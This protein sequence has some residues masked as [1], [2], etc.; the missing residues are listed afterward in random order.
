MFG[1]R[2]AIGVGW[3]ALALAL[4][5]GC[6]GA[7][8]H[9]GAQ[10]AAG[11]TS[12]G[13]SA[14]GRSGSGSGGTSIGRA[15]TANSGGSSMDAGPMERDPVDSGCPMDSMQMAQNEC[16]PFVVG[17]CPPGAGCYPFV[18]H[19][20][21]SGCDQQVYGTVCLPA[22]QGRQGDLCGDDASELCAPGFACVVGQRAGKR[23][24]ALCK[25]GGVNQCSGGLICGDLDVP[26]F[27]V[28]G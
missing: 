16:D 17:S 21:G 25:L 14:V 1:C 13:G 23:C 11:D 15:G 26:G 22:G 3:C 28:C 18:E 5:V 7:T 12:S 19:P 10:A 2:T 9:G 27:G 4:A 8:E 6:G 20:E 24:A